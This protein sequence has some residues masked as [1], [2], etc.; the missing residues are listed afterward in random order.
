[1]AEPW[2]SVMSELFGGSSAELFVAN[3][4]QQALCNPNRHA[5]AGHHG[6]LGLKNSNSILSGP[7]ATR[8]GMLGL[9]NSNSILS[10]PHATRT[11]MPMPVTTAC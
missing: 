6:M 9:K 1:M 11:G 10:G 2:N 5:H 3:R 7:H 4:E 8:T